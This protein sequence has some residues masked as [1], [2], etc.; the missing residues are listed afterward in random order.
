MNSN[1]AKALAHSLKI[2]RV[3][4]SGQ[5]RPRNEDI[6][7]NWGN[8]RLPSWI[9]PTFMD[10]KILNKPQA[11]A[12]ASSKVRTFQ[13]LARAMPGDIPDFTTS[14]DQAR[15][16]LN[17]AWPYSTAKLVIC[18]TL[19]RANSGR[20]IVL[21][22][23]PGE[24]VPAPLYTRY[25]PKHAEYRVHVSEQFGIVDI[26]Q[27]RKK[28]VAVFSASDKYIRSHDHG[29]VFCRENLHVPDRILESAQLA[30]HHLGL[31]FGAVDIG[32]HTKYGVGIYE[33][34]T[35]PGLEGHTLDS[36]T[37]LFRKYTLA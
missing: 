30:V 35:A 17:K 5:Y 1:S 22:A 34:N 36:Y 37:K 11:I 8:S 20:G 12:N 21:A 32:Y 9:T 7:I 33:V 31:D 13:I 18:R 2:L 3:R 29:W 24:I 28:N 25:K 14:A 26:Q 27:K 16:W 19:T 4:K 6:V 23:A 10:T 15:R